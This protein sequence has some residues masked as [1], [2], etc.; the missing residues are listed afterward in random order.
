[1]QKIAV[2]KRSWLKVLLGVYLF[3][4]SLVCFS[5]SVPPADWPL[6]AFMFVLAIFGFFLAR[7]ASRAWRVVW[8]AALIFSLVCAVL[9]VVAGKR[10][11]RQRTS[12][13]TVRSIA[14]VEILCW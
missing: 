11:A 1:M 14:V 13:L 12:S 6:C 5:L 4:L 10:I 3:P 9:E 8:I 2:N 7:G